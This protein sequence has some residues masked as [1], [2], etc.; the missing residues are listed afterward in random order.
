MADYIADRI[1][2]ARLLDEAWFACQAEEK[3]VMRAS[4]LG[5]IDY[6]TEPSAPDLKSLDDAEVERLYRGTLR[7]VAADSRR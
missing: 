7:K 5:Q 3:N 6:E 4:V 1:P 2:T